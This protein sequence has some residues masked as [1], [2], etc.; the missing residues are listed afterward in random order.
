MKSKSDDK[1]KQNM[2]N[3]YYDNGQL[4]ERKIEFKANEARPNTIILHWGIN[5][6]PF[7]R[8]HGKPR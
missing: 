8:T 3:H 4:R 5:Y 1:V 2:D 7:H 6:L